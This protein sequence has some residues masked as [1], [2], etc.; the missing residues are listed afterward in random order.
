MAEAHVF[1]LEGSDS[2]YTYDNSEDDV[3]ALIVTIQTQVRKR[4]K[5]NLCNLESG[6]LFQI[7]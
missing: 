7:H 4:K 3:S 5:L 2:D 6:K 1:Y